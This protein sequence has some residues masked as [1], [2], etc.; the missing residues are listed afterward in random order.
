MRTEKK[1]FLNRNDDLA[2]AVDRLIKT[3]APVVILN[4]PRDSV[5]A[6]TINNFHV[7]RRESVAAQKELI[8]ESVDER[9]LELAALAKLDAVNPVF[10]QKERLISDILPK[11]KFKEKETKEKGEVFEKKVIPPAPEKKVFKKPKKLRVLKGVATFLIVAFIV[12]GGFLLMNTV[13]P[14]ATV[15][16]ILK[17]FP[18]NFLYQVEVGTTTQSVKVNEGKILLPG[19]LLQASGNLSLSFPASGQKEVQRKATGT[20]T[21]FNAYSSLPQ[22]LVATTR[23]LSP[24]GKV[25]RLDRQVTIPGAKVEDGKIVPSQIEVSVTADEPG[26]DYNIGPAKNWRIPGFKGSPRYEG[27]YADSLSAMTGGF[28]GVEAVPTAEDIEKGRRELLTKLEGA[29]E[30]QIL[31]LLSDRF[32]VFPQS[33]EFKVLKEEIEPAS[34]EGNFRIFIEAELK[35]LVF[36]EIILKEA[37]T[38]EVKNSFAGDLKV[39]DFSLSYSEPKTALDQGKMTF[40]ISGSIIFEPNINVAELKQEFIGRNEQELRK[41]VFFLTG[42]ERANISLWPFWV[43]RVPNDPERLIVIL[44]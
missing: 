16:M 23:F 37:V 10:R 20:L 5:L 13:L 12:F 2:V 36:D 26:E 17:K 18:A 8:I 43:N 40:S 14:K 19:E 22:V 39:K 42:L 33:R 24:Q 9:V 44:K 32:K 30:G 1:V 27:F 25:F 28:V 11:P 15:E 31:V 3:Q 4:I 7:L 35:Y 29:L 38:A 21:V 6:T 34:S 41:A